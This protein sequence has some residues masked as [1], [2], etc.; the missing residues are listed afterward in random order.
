MRKLNIIISM[1]ALSAMVI[2][3][4][5]SKGTQKVEAKTSLITTAS[6]LQYED[7]TEG[8]GEV[9]KVGQTMFVHYKGYLEN[10]TVFDNSYDRKQ[11]IQVS[12]PPKNLIQGWIE[13]IPPVKK[14][15]KRKLIIPP[16]LGYG[17]RA[18]GTIPPN[19]KLIFEIEV[20]DIK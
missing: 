11:P 12:V 14:G 5:H 6:G 19:S 15:G 7:I 1:L 2:A 3:C 8:T 10:G 13:G 16:S 4:S 18:M 9:A 20:V 17:S